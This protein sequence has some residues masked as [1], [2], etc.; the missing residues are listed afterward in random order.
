MSDDYA[1]LI[2]EEFGGRV[3]A[4]IG[5]SYGGLIACYLA[6]DHSDRFRLIVLLIAAH[7]VS[8]IGREIDYRYARLLSE[9]KPRQATEAIVEA[10]FPKGISA[11]LMKG[12]GWLIGPALSKGTHASY[13][14]DVLIEAQ[15]EWGPMMSISPR[16][17]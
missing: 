7:R 17:S 11:A 6:A 13:R 4:V 14:S 16:R 1:R 2:E 8:D 12:I 9:G 3:D 15:A 10:L 5:M